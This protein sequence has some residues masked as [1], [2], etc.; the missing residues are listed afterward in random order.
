VRA[1]LALT[2]PGS[3]PVWPDAWWLD[4]HHLR[5]AR[6]FPVV[7]PASPPGAPSKGGNPGYSLREAAYEKARQLHAE[8]KSPGEIT[9]YLCTQWAQMLALPK[10][11]RPKPGT[12]AGW[13]RKALK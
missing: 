5:H 11:S 6:I 13:R 4:G 12:V 10:T 3:G 9:H 2:K 8:G 1:V 7:A